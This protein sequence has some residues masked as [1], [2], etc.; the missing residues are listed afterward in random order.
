VRNI[1]PDPDESVSEHVEHFFA[2]NHRDNYLS[3][4]VLIFLSFCPL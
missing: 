2:V 1:P 3:H 4:Q